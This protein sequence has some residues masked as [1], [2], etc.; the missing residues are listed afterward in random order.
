MYQT[1]N[2][3]KGDSDSQAKLE[4]LC[5]PEDLTGKRVLDLGCNEGFFCFEAEKRGA[6]VVGLDIDLKSIEYANSLKTPDSKITFILDSWNNINKLED[7]YDF[8]LWLSALH[9]ARDKQLALLLCIVNKYLTKDGVLILECGVSEKNP[10]EFYVE[11]YA[12]AECEVGN[13]PHYPN[14]KTLLRYLCRY[15][16]KVI[17]E[18][19]NQGG[20]KIPRYVFHIRRPSKPNATLIYGDPG[21]GKSYIGSKLAIDGTAFVQWEILFMDWLK[22]HKELTEGFGEIELHL[23]QI[24]SKAL[25]E[26]FEEN[27]VSYF[28]SRIKKYDCDVVVEGY[29]VAQIIPSLKTQLAG[30]FTIRIVSVT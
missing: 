5:L 30:Q 15:D 14:M 16:V 24:W 26:G 22:E 25:K 12:R 2:G 1:F 11:K 17:G 19:V 10:D 7:K 23:G 3:V 29:G 28:V 6:E 27:L 9:Y 18:S 13:E 20:D 4:K 21:S 8:I